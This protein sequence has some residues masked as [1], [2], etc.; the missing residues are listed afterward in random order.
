MHPNSLNIPSSSSPVAR[1]EEFS[2]DP[3]NSSATALDG[4]GLRPTACVSLSSSTISEILCDHTLM[5][6]EYFLCFNITNITA[7]QKSFCQVVNEACSFQGEAFLRFK[8]DILLICLQDASPDHAFL[9]HHIKR[10]LVKQRPQFY[11]ASIAAS[12]EQLLCQH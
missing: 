5:I 7:L 4:T 3:L 12:N 8:G 2:R 10:I 9:Q 6:S 11:P 1:K